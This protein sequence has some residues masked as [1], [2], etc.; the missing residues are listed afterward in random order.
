[1]VKVPPLKI[2]LSVSSATGVA[3]KFALDAT[4]MV[5]AVRVVEPV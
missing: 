2:M 3:P 4:L 5:P 1:M